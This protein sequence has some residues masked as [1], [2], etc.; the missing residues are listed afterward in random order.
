MIRVILPAHLRV[1]ARVEGEIEIE[2]PAPV[3]HRAILDTLEATY[4]VLSGTMR[5]H[6]THD[7]RRLVRFFTCETD[8]S[9]A[10]P[11]T[12]VPA[13]VAAGREPFLIVG[14]MAGG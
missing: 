12:P 8:V 3:T 4:P 1:L 7:R 2:V 11:D 5:D 10:P 14:A 13:A 9:H 6:V